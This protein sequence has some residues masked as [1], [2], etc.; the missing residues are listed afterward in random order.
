[1]SKATFLSNAGS[2]W[3]AFHHDTYCIYNIICMHNMGCDDKN[4]VHSVLSDIS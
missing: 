1:M 4:N 3:F 2:F